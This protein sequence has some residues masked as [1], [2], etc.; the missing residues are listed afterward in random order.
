MSGRDKASDQLVDW[1][2]KNEVRNKTNGKNIY[3][4][5]LPKQ[6]R[7]LSPNSNLSTEF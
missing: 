1:Q 2:K 7:I 4:N 3:F 5:L 6:L